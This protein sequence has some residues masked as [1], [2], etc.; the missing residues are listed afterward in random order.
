[1]ILTMKEYIYLNEEFANAVR[2]IL[3]WSNKNT[4]TGY[5]SQEDAAPFVAHLPE[6]WRE[7]ARI[8]AC[9]G[10]YGGADDW[11]RDNVE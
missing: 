9:H 4:R 6:F 3:D 1:M 8:M 10:Y 11:F 7:P 5:V 2:A